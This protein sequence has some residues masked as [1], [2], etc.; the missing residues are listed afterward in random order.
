MFFVTHRKIF[1][2]IAAVLVLGSGLII[3]TLGLNPGIDFVGGALTEVS[4]AERPDKTEVSEK[5]D[6]LGL[7]AYSLRETLDEEGRDGYILRTRD[8]SEDERVSVDTEVTSVG[9]DATVTRFTSIGPVIGQELKDKAL[10]AIVAVSLIIILYVAFAFRGVSYPVGSWAYGGI[11]ILALLHDVLVP[12]AVMALLGYFLG[13]EADVLFVMA[14]LA[15]LGY[16]V[17]DTIVVFD[18]VREN[19]V[20]FRQEKKVMVV[21]TD[22]LEREEIEY[23]LT[24]PFENIVGQSV[25]QTLMRSINTSVT[26]LV[27]LLALYFVGGEVTQTFSLVLIAGVIAGT[28]S[29]ICIA[30]PLL[31]MV[32]ERKLKDN[33]ETKVGE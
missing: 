25:T 17:N 20:K 1:L 28:Y 9:S 11:T 19:L 32:A 7:G 23:I 27:A 8:L 29:S 26:T 16:S 5:L 12:S 24:K 33:K 30:N 31:V 2:T 15:V 6:V 3:G 22:G 4:Y 18:R 14:L 10:W 13:I 21:S